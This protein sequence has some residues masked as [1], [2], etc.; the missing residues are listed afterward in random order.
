V[1][2]GRS[3]GGLDGGTGDAV[4]RLTEWCIRRALEM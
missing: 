3:G 4:E 2:S 1:R